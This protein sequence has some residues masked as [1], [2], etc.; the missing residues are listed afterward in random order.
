MQLEKVNYQKVFATAAYQNEK[1]GLE[2]SIDKG[3]D[4]LEVLA[5]LKSIAEKFH[6]ENNPGL[7]TQTNPEPFY[8]VREEPST[9]T[10]LLIQEPR[11]AVP[12][13]I[14]DIGTCTSIKTLETYKFIAKSNPEIQAAYD[15]KYNELQN[16][17][18]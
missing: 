13:I 14:Q 10:P 17:Q 12:L 4:P 16:K 15:S 6:R 3:E 18:P 7:Y 5:E 11:T 1:I 9:G 8:T 2:A